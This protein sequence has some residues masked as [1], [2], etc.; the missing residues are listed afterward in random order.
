MGTL[1]VPLKTGVNLA[2]SFSFSQSLSRSMMGDQYRGEH[3]HYND[4]AGKYSYVIRPP[5][6]PKHQAKRLWISGTKIDIDATLNVNSDQSL[7][8]WQAGFLQSIHRCERTAIYESGEK[9]QIRLNTASGPLKDGDEGEIFYPGSMVDLS[10]SGKQASCK[11]NMEDA[12]NW[13]APIVLTSL[14]QSGPSKLN[15]TKGGDS[16]ST[17]LA[18]AHKSSKTLIILGGYEWSIDWSG[19]FDLDRDKPWQPQRTPLISVDKVLGTSVHEGLQA[20]PQGISLL[21]DEA[22]SSAEAWDRSAQNWKR[23]SMNGS[24]NPDDLPKPPAANTWLQTAAAPTKNAWAAKSS[25]SNTNATSAPSKWV[26]SRGRGK[27]NNEED[28]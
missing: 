19:T 20:A 10:I 24:T 21:T 4:D 25:P 1:L 2:L 28:K 12:P 26:F 7:K 5:K 16:F 22:E 9:F 18:L 23:S 27:I 13:A 15:E 17:R 6:P 3:K 11:P 8:G 14:D